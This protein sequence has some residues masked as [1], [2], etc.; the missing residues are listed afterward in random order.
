MH[1]HCQKKQKTNKKTLLNAV[2]KLQMC[3]LQADSE[4][5]VLEDAESAGRKKICAN[6]S[7]EYIY[8]II[9]VYNKTRDVRYD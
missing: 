6:Y 3:F 7:T 9:S 4:C 1:K 5:L 2:C 8:G